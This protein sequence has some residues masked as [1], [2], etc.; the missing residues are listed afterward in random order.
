MS[1]TVENATP[2]VIAYRLVATTL[3]MKRQYQD[4]GM[5]VAR[6]FCDEHGIDVYE[7]ERSL[8]ANGRPYGKRG[9]IDATEPWFWDGRKSSSA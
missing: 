6:E 1:A 8:R 3:M 4:A 2:L 7:V 9:Q 5:M